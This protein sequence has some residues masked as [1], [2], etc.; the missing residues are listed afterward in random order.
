M[1]LV[2]PLMRFL[3]R[4]GVMPP[5]P[6][7]IRLIMLVV[8]LVRLVVTLPVRPATLLT[9]TRLFSDWW[10]FEASGAD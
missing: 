9:F 8:P 6:L 10:N 4:L 1:V 5:I 2:V 7:V 3:V